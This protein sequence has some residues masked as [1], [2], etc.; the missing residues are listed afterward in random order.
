MGAPT[1]WLRP[2]NMKPCISCRQDMMKY[3]PAYF[4]HG[5]QAGLEKESDNICDEC[6]L[7]GYPR[8]YGVSIPYPCKNACGQLILVESVTTPKG[9]FKS[10]NRVNCDKCIKEKKK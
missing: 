4:L 7:Y 9:A 2:E 5:S 10:N 8:Q 6:Q 1:P 3:S